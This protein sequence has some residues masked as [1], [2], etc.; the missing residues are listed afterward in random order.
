MAGNII[1]RNEQLT[2]GHDWI[3]PRNEWTKYSQTSIHQQNSTYFRMRRGI[4]LPTLTRPRNRK[5]V[6]KFLNCR[7][8]SNQP[9][10]RFPSF[11]KKWVPC[12]TAAP[13][14]NPTNVLLYMVLIAVQQYCRHVIQW[15]S[16][17]QPNEPWHKIIMREIRQI[18]AASGI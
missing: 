3:Y 11:T 18:G 16:W 10:I 13:P 2:I 5:I 4:N 14:H 17:R 8:Q 6:L 12:V 9:T 1:Y 15:K 7:F